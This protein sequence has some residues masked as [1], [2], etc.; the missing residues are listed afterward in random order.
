MFDFNSDQF[1]DIPAWQEARGL[2]KLVYEHTS[3]GPWALEDVLRHE[4]RQSAISIVTKIAQGSARQD[5]TEFRRMVSQ[6]RSL[7]AVVK[8][9]LYLAIDLEFLDQAG[10]DAVNA[11]VEST[12]RMIDFLADGLKRGSSR[13]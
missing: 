10:F 13:R 2:V 4:I 8:T 7:T 12:L 1:E 3:A 5:V 11:A 9:H 6:A